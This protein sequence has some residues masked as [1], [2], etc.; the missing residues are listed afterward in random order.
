MGQRELQASPLTATTEANDFAEASP[1]RHGTE[2]PPPPGPPGEDRHLG[3]RT[4]PGRRTYG[5]GILPGVPAFGAYGAHETID[6]GLRRPSGLQRHRKVEPPAQSIAP[7]VVK[8]TGRKSTLTNWPVPSR[9]KRSGKAASSA[10][11]TPGK[12][13]TGRS[14]ATGHIPREGGDRFSPRLPISAEF[15][16]VALVGKQ[17]RVSACDPVDKHGLAGGEIENA[18]SGRIEDGITELGDAWSAFF[19]GPARKEAE[20]V[21]G[22]QFMTGAD[23]VSVPKSES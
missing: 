11:L 21:D 5:W 3:R 16:D 8:F 1:S 2:A 10:A 20:P 7:G 23:V 14:S 15:Q 13:E 19:A 18:V 22:D 6:R 9:T 12:V 17:V 4:A